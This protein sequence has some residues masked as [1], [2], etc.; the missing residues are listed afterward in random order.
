MT[1]P[2]LTQSIMEAMDVKD[3]MARNY[4]KYMKDNAII[5]NGAINCA[6]DSAEF[7]MA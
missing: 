7:T 4:I 2:E 1:I 5:E 6:I 3:R